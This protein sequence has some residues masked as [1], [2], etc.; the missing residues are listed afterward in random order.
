MSGYEDSPSINGR[1]GLNVDGGAVKEPL[2]AKAGSKADGPAH[3]FDRDSM[4][5]CGVCILGWRPYKL[6][7]RMLW[8]SCALYCIRIALLQAVM[9]FLTPACRG[10]A[11]QAPLQGPMRRSL[12]SC[13]IHLGRHSVRKLR[14]CWCYSTFT[15][16]RK[17]A[18]RP[19]RKAVSGLG[20]VTIWV[21]GTSSHVQWVTFYIYGAGRHTP[22]VIRR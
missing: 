6:G 4:V 13:H 2:K 15:D 16:A 1:A 7:A 8:L 22:Q 21:L 11:A 3:G 9:C 19:C 18:D 10:S 17:A 5:G 20:A 12:H 14:G